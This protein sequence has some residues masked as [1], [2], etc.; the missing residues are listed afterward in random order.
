MGCTIY[1]Q[2]SDTATSEVLK[3][4]LNCSRPVKLH[5]NVGDPA[6]FKAYSSITKCVGI[7]GALALLINAYGAY[8]LRQADI[9]TKQLFQMGAHYQLVHSIAM[10]GT[11][12]VT[13]PK[14]E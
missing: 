12:F 3:R 9:R 1:L 14:L 13:Y 10:L 5:G 6:H 11:P 4:L 8:R 7:C 2:E